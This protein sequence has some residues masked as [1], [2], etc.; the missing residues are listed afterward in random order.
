MKSRAA[1]D[2]DEDGGRGGW[3]A[4]QGVV[5]KGEGEGSDEGRGGRANLQIPSNLTHLQ[6]GALCQ[7]PH[8]IMG[9]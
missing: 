6:I 9:K 8:C 1:H 2:V 3:M 7:R 4:L 5:K